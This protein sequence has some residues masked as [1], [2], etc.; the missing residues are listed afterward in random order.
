[1]QSIRITSRLPSRIRKW[2]QFSH[3]R[4]ISTM[5]QGFKRS[6]KWSTNSPSTSTFVAS[7]STRIDMKTIFHA[8]LHGK[9]IGIM[10]SFRRKKLHKTNWCSNFLGG[11]FSKK[12]N[13][14]APIQ[15]RKERQPQHLKIWFFL[16][17]RPIQI[18]TSIAPVSLSQSNETSWV[19]WALKLISHFLL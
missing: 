11:S 10:R 9:F 2:N 15:F 1:M 3:F 6:I 19:F 5:S 13:V 7:R 14:T 16:K 18:S 12:D 8:W 4:W 17:N